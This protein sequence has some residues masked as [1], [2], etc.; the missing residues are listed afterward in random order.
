MIGLEQS[1][2]TLHQVRPER[3]QCVHPLSSSHY[4]VSVGSFTN[5]LDRCTLPRFSKS[6]ISFENSSL[7]ANFTMAKVESS[8]I[9]LAAPTKLVPLS[10]WIVLGLPRL[11]MNL[12][13]TLM[14]QSVSKDEANSRCTARE[15]RQ[16]NKKPHLLTTALP[17]FA[18]K[19]PK[20]STPVCVKQGSK[21]VVR[22][23][24][25]SAI[26]C[27]IL[28]ALCFLHFRHDPTTLQTKDLPFGIQNVSLSRA[29][30]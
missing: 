5:L 24:G 4:P 16:V 23:V 8:L 11:L 28:G 1:L 26:I 18:F 29:R 21:V 22:N 20:R 6:L 3:Q 19:G 2:G 27:F 15:L 17:L 10:E 25:K 30:M 13:R 9:S 14:K 7:W 12:H